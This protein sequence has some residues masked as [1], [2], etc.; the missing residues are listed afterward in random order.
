MLLLC[1][2]AE[3]LKLKSKSKRKAK[4]NF[5]ELYLK[6]C[7]QHLRT[8]PIKYHQ[9]MKCPTVTA[10]F[11]KALDYIYS[12]FRCLYAHEGM[13]RLHEIKENG[14]IG[15]IH[16]FL[17]D[18]VDNDRYSIDLLKVFDWFA[19]ITKSSLFHSL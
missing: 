3:S 13:G 8:P 12:K 16:A 9:N 7:P 10:P 6:F 14:N 4:Q 1:S 5:K 17:F 2:C 18:I 11:D 15:S 19:G